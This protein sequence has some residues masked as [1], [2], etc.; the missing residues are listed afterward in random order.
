MD[1]IDRLNV[2]DVLRVLTSTDVKVRIVLK[3]EADQISDRVFAP[4]RA[5]LLPIVRK[6]PMSQ[7][8]LLPSAPV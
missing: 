2:E 6:P 4:P 3:G 7:S 1:W 5:S 8:G